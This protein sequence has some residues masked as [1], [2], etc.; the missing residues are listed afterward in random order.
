[1]NLIVEDSKLINFKVKLWA[2]E[3]KELTEAIEKISQIKKQ[4]AKLQG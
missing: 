1:M 3:S 4:I 2:Y